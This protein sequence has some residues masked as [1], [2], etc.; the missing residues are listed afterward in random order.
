MPVGYR[1]A[2]DAH[3]AGV[4]AV[5][6]AAGGSV[7]FGRQK[8]LADLRGEPLLGH[9]LR[10]VLAAGIGHLVLVVT[11]ALDL[12]GVEASADGRVTI[13]INPD[14]ARGMFSSVQTGLAA[15]RGGQV[16]VV[17]PGDMPFVRSTTIAKVSHESLEAA[18]VVVAC[19]RGTRGHP[20]AMPAATARAILAAPGDSTLSAEL[21]RAGPVYELDVDDPGVVRDVDSP[22]DLEGG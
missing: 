20:V 9:T 18:A 11:P 4:S 16:V 22:K 8:L 2:S 1:A 7:R 14:P 21:H 3:T 10:S 15:V 19:Y 12:S 17:L 5:V 6:V 13:A